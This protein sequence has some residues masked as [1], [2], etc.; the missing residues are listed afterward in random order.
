MLDGAEQLPSGTLVS[1]HQLVVWLIQ[2]CYYWFLLMIVVKVL[3]MMPT[4]H[5]L[6]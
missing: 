3:M 4:G 1:L 2:Y 5:T 6:V